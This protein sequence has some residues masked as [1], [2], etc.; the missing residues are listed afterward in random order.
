MSKSVLP[1]AFVIVATKGRTREM[2]GLFDSL[3]RQSLLPIRVAVVGSEAAD[4]QGLEMHE[5]ALSG[6]AILKTSPTAGTCIQRNVGLNMLADEIRAS[7][8][9]QTFLVFFDDDFRPAD[10]WLEQ[11]ARSFAEQLDVVGITGDVISDGVRVSGYNEAEAAQYISGER[12]REPHWPHNGQRHDM[13]GGGLYGCN[14]A[15]RGNAALSVRFDEA[16]PLYGWQEDIDFAARV[17]AFGRLIFEPACRGVHMG[18]QGARTSGLRFG[19]SQIANPVYLIRK[20]SMRWRF[21]FRLAARN[22]AS[23]LFNTLRANRSKDYAG[24]LRGNAIALL[25]ALRW[26]Q[27]PM[28]VLEL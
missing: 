12:P 4:I 15:Y 5:L 22:V 14:M 25:D 3:A 26:R 7:E 1:Q 8:P 9:T 23:N 2:V 17:A 10:D 13:R 20:G 28:R 11:C 27:H 16:L 21:G 24:R 6:R 18:V 19:Y